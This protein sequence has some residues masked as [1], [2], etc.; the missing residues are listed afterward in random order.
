MPGQSKVN[1]AWRTTTGL[2]VKVGGQWK[3]ATS[4]FI[5]VGGVWKQWYASRLEDSFSRSSTVLSLGTS[6]SGQ[7]WENISG[8]WKVNG[9][10]QAAS[11]DSPSSYPIAAVE[12][13]SS[14]F[15]VRA[16]VTGGTG[17]AFWVQNSSNWWAA[18]PK[19]SYADG[20]YKSYVEIIKKEGAV[21]S[22]EE[23]IV[24]YSSSGYT[25]INSISVVSK[26]GL[27]YV[28]AFSDSLATTLLSVP[29]VD[30]P[31]APIL[32]TK[33]GIIKAP[34]SDSQGSTIDNIYAVPIVDTQ[35][36]PAEYQS[37]IVLDELYCSSYTRKH[38]A[39][40]KKF[41]ADANATITD[42]YIAD[43]VLATNSAVCGYVPPPPPPP[44]PGGGGCS[45]LNGSPCG[46]GGTYNCFGNCIGST[47]P[48][49]Y[50]Q[51][52]CTC[53][54]GCSSNG[55]IN[56]DGVCSGQVC[57]NPTC[58]TPYSC[59]GNYLY[60]SCGNLVNTCAI[61]CGCDNE[62]PAPPPPPP[63]PNCEDIPCCPCPACGIR[64][65]NTCTGAVSGSCE[66]C[67]P[68]PPPPPP[69]PPPPT[70]PCAGISC[71][72]CYAC[73]LGFCEFIGCPSTPPPPPPPPPPPSGCVPDQ[74]G[75][76]E[77][78]GY[79]PGGQCV[80]LGT[81]TCSG[82]CTSLGSIIC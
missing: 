23:L 42:V 74:G 68:A 35:T 37:G 64:Y 33:L 73:Y 15:S 6:E 21:S 46:C 2:F 30:Q 27:L 81:I 77:V 65:R 9:S 13:N 59:S 49:N 51:S 31:T 20:L 69:P 4:A 79:G 63:N 60:D 17:I 16:A 52:C 66:P 3:T 34:T 71:P 36:L 57:N 40:Y 12:L 62:P 41:F 72:T 70:N 58:G 44:P 1:G 18:V 19:Y 53:A 11:D 61:V 56:C 67:P 39:G 22:Y 38:R 8:T 48:A 26:A 25:T 55:T 45:P 76:C 50:G 75:I 43:I 78:G 80:R 29:Y 24:N 5:K 14:E 32:G 7:V 28:R 10:Q 47:A 54:N 82:G